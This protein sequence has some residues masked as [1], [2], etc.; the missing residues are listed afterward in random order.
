MLYEE[1]LWCKREYSTKATRRS[2]TERSCGSVLLFTY[3]FVYV[4]TI[5]VRYV[6]FSEGCH[7]DVVRGPSTSHDPEGDAGGS[8]SF[9]QGHPSR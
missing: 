1:M 6:R 3:Y 7:L 4:I 9:W 8:F 2:E 5:N